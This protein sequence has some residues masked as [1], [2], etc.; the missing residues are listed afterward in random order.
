MSCR[1]SRIDELSLDMSCRRMFFRHAQ[2]ASNFKDSWL[3]IHVN[4]LKVHSSENGLKIQS[5][6]NKN[7]QVLV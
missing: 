3:E 1:F 6:V 5:M 7:D 4:K 2:F